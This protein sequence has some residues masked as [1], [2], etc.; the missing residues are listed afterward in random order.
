MKNTRSEGGI[1]GI[2]AEVSEPARA[3]FLLQRTQGKLGSRLGKTTGWAH[4]STLKKKGVK[5]MGGVQYNKI[6]DKGL[7]ITI[8]DEQMVLEVDNII[9]CAGQ[10]SLNELETELKAAGIPAHVIGGAELAAELDAKRAIE[11]GTK[12][13]LK[14]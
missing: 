14:I 1:E 7:H 2:E 3:V 5:M 8:N 12:L 13:A 11:Q 4:R 9:I 6:D 10:V